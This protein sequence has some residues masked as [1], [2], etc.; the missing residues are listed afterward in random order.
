M[1]S[2]Q[3]STLLPKRLW[4]VHP[5][6]RMYFKPLSKSTGVNFYPESARPLGCTPSQLRLNKTKNQLK[7]AEKPA[8]PPQRVSVL[9]VCELSYVAFDCSEYQATLKG[10]KRYITR[11]MITQQKQ[12]LLHFYTVWCRSKSLHWPLF[13][14]WAWIG[15][16]S[17]RLLNTQKHP[18]KKTR[19]LWNTTEMYPKPET[20]RN[21]TGIRHPY[22]R[23]YITEYFYSAATDLRW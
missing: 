5:L 11:V 21:K 2:L 10:K 12:Y 3:L 20:Q 16:G 15:I 1:S 6:L 7:H 8:Q 17:I 9:P 19:R 14:F 22:F 23:F 4:A 13:L 18:Q